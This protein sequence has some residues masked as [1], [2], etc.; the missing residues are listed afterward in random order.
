MRAAG[1]ISVEKGLLSP[2]EFDLQQSVLERCGLP[3]SAPSVDRGAVL[4]AT[5]L[6]K[7]VTGGRVRWVLLD[8]IG[9]ASI[10][11]DV[12]ES[13]VHHAVDTVLS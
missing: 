9:H 7:K 6:D 2:E 13:L 4:Q 3:A 10:H 5:L 12:D 11:A 8:R 1:I